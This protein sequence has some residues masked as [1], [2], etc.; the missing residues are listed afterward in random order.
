MAFNFKGVNLDDENWKIAN[1]QDQDFPPTS[2]LA[3]PADIN[4]QARQGFRRHN[5]LGINTFVMEF[6]RHY[7]D[8]LGVR[9]KSFMTSFTNG[10]PQAIENADAGA[11]LAS[12]EVEVISS[13]QAGNQVT[14][15]IEIRNLAGHRFPSGVSFRRLFLEVVVLD[16]AGQVIWG[17][18]RTNTLGVIVDGSGNPLPSE[19][20]QVDPATGMERYQ[21][22]Y[23]VVDSED[24][25]QIYAELIKDSNG[26]FTTS[27]LA[28]ADIVKDNRLLP[29]GWSNNGP[30]GF[31]AEFAEATRPHGLAASDPDFTDGQGRD[32]ITYVSTLPLGAAGP[33]QVRASLYYQSIPPVY[34][35]DRFNQANG[36]ATRR[37]HYL[38]AHL[39]DSKTTFQNWKQPVDSTQAAV[40]P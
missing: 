39:D 33:F 37:L 13:N 2:F 6:F 34:L 11:R 8:I 10:L 20:H 40:T 14:T 27:F 18:G 35:N 31:D 26:K 29:A 3:P 7:P 32:R 36:P 30:A 17:S 12:G 15:V 5:L 19:F 1:I 38:A 21:P 24:K 22:H 4:V 25:A 23:Q 16:G 9:T 28:R